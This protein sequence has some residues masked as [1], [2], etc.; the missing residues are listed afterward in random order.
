M[1][2]LFVLL[3]AAA[4]G[5]AA[6][7]PDA[8]VSAAPARYVHSLAP[9]GSDPL[10]NCSPLLAIAEGGHAELTITDIVNPGTIQVEGDGLRWTA[11]GAADVPASIYFSASAN[12][13]VLT[14]DYNHWD[15]T[16]LRQ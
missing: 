13:R 6:S 8:R 7:S 3:F 10:V 5:D 12:G 16:Q 2:L 4:C 14:D 1:R 15:W 11:D 9:C